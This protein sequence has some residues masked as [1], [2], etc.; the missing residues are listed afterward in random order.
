MNNTNKSN[1]RKYLSLTGVGMAGLMIIILLII[2]INGNTVQ[3][4]PPGNQAY[5]EPYIGSMHPHIVSEGPGTCEVC[6]M[7]LIKLDGHTP[8]TPLPPLANIYTSPDNPMYVHE[9]PGKDP[10]SGSDL[11]PIVN[12]SIY[13]APAGHDNAHAG[14]D[15]EHVLQVDDSGLYTCGMHPDVIQDEP[16]NC[17]ICGMDLTPLKSYGSGQSGGERK[18]AYWTAPM[19]PN[20]ISDRPGKSPM[21]MDLVPVYDDQVTGGV[22]SIDPVTVQNIGVTT[23]LVE[24]RDL[25]T[26]I[27]SNGSVNIDKDAE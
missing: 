27:R 14:A 22:V 6:G 12:S 26:R 7:N 17:P 10:K 18:I 15:E 23:T 5:N 2:S 24:S 8:G 9:G 20:Y 25:N 13:E 11:I 16:G 4:K 19:D 21:G 3:S 1:L